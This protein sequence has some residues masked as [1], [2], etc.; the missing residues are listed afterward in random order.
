MLLMLTQTFCSAPA[1][2]GPKIYIIPEG[3]KIF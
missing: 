2:K 1:R 3:R